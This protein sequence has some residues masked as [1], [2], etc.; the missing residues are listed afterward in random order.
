MFCD[1]FALC[2]D[3]TFTPL[4]EFIPLEFT[5]HFA[6]TPASVFSSVLNSGNF[7]MN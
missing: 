4:A 6:N 3:L 2:T 7:F 1:I 5:T